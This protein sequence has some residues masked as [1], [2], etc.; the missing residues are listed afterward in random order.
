LALHQHRLGEEAGRVADFSM[1]LDI[2]AQLLN[3]VA[4]R[5][6]EFVAGRFCASQALIGLRGDSMAPVGMSEDRSPIWPDG[7][8]GSITHSDSI[9][10]AA[11]GEHEIYRGIGIDVES[12]LDH[13]RA[14]KISK[15]I[16]L[17][18]ETRKKWSVSREF[19]LLVTLIFSLKESLFKALHPEAKRFF[20]FSSAK[21]VEIDWDKRCFSVELM[22]TLSP[23]YRQGMQFYGQFGI[24]EE[25]VATLITVNR[26]VV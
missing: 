19:S 17:P 25:R 10:L 26:D 13:D 5:K 7:I 9:V 15:K 4:R 2:P 23:F 20:G 18:D 3:A 24:R 11:V 16:L 8:V 1:K 22:E 21:V 14:C 6:N 12:V